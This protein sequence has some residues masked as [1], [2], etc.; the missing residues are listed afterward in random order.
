M[1]Y[2]KEFPFSENE[3]VVAGPGCKKGLDYIFKDYDGMTSEEA[4]F[5]LRDNI[6]FVFSWDPKALFSDLPEHDRCLNIMSLENCM[7]ELAKYIRTIEG[8][9]RPRVKYKQHK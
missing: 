9:G 4:L 1:T 3:F 5:W 7:C 8:T 2:I 6:D